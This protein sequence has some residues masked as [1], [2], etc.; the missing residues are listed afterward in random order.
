LVEQV[1]VREQAKQRLQRKRAKV[2]YAF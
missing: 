1:L 2:E